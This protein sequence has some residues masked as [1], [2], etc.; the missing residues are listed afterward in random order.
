MYKRQSLPHPHDVLV[1]PTASVTDELERNQYPGA[2]LGR[3]YRVVELAL[4]SGSEDMVEVT[5]GQLHKLLGE[6]F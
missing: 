3:Y 1:T 2:G 4:E 5:L 6:F